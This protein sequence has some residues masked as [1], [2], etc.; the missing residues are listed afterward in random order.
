MGKRTIVVLC[1]ILGIGIA[2]GVY[3][4]T[5]ATA[6]VESNPVATE[7]VSQEFGYTSY[8]RAL[9]LYA[10]DSGMV[11]YGK[12]QENRGDL[13]AFTAMLGRLDPRVL[14]SWS[15]EERIAFWI[16]AYNALTL[17]A[18]IDHY[19]IQSRLFRGFLYPKNSIRQIPG[20][21]TELQWTI[22]GQ[23]YT[24]DAIEHEV[25]R[26]EFSEPRIH[27]ALVCAAMGCPPLRNEPYTG[28]NLSEQLDEQM[29]RFLS[30]PTKFRIDRQG[31]TVYLSPIFEWFGKDFVEKYSS[32]GFDGHSAV[33]RAVLN[34]VS[35]FVSPEDRAYLVDERYSV[36][37]L[38]YDWTLNEQ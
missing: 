32:D 7:P 13:D 14:D 20:V 22:V 29:R 28:E 27:A 1:L 17:T 24:L 36:Q 38:D 26:G 11:D 5:G 37:Y 2:S 9:E 10:D 25:L 4:L 23:S 21:W 6:G 16:N 35:N 30:N 12:L 34:A 3:L 8:A 33:E 19:P 31:G 15:A 18:V